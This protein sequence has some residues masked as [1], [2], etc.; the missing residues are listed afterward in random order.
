MKVLLVCYYGF[1]ESIAS[2]V[3]SLTKYGLNIV[4]YPLMKIQHEIK[5]GTIEHFKTKITEENPDIILWWYLGISSQEL[6]EIEDLIKSR[7]NIFFNWDEP[8]V[9]SMEDFKN[10][11]KYMDAVFA[12][13]EESL[14]RYLEAG[15]RAAY[16]CLP[17][18]DPKDNFKIYDHKEEIKKKYTCDISIAC[19]NLYEKEDIYPNQYINRKTIIDNIYNNQEQYGYVFHIYGPEF[20]GK[21][22]PNSYKGFLDYY[23][24]NYLFNYSKINLCTHVM[25][26]KYK[27][28]NQRSLLILGSGGLLFVDYISGLENLITPNEECILIDKE[29]YIDQIVSILNNYEQFKDVRENGRLKSFKYTWNNWAFT[30]YENYIKNIKG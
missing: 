26:D 3:T 20:L 18:Y 29:N 17:G 7:K 25:C 19:T 22:Y 15:S 11:P 12:C 30:I 2:A 16:Y 4:E 13:C 21:L 27:M 14:G 5:D 10:K 9:W 23:D 6:Q 8:Y 24:T 1:I 28:L